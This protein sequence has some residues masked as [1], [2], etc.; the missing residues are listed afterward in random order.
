M[1]CG[2]GGGGTYIPFSGLDSD[3]PGD[4]A[5]SVPTGTGEE[6][7]QWGGCSGTIWRCL[8]LPTTEQESVL[9]SERQP[10]WFPEEWSLSNQEEESKP[11]LGR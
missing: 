1:L 9:N 8:W 3:E 4:S 11:M 10:A 7:V 5:G 6:S 2:T